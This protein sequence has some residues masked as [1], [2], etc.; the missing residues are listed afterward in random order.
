MFRAA[1]ALSKGWL[2]PLN[3]IVDSLFT[4]KDV[5]MG[6]CPNDRQDAWRQ[7]RR[8]YYRGARLR[9][10]LLLRLAVRRN[11]NADQN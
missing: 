9:L 8:V 10:S 1:C 4:G 7:Y 5:G 6:I 11:G 3:R 2:G